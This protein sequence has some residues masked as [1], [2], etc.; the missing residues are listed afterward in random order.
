MEFLVGELTGKRPLLPPNVEMPKE[1]ANVINT[2]KV[3]SELPSDSLGAYVISMAKSASDVMAVVLL[4]VCPPL[5]PKH[6]HRP[7]HLHARIRSIHTTTVHAP[8]YLQHHAVLST[9]PLQAI[10]WAQRRAL[11]VLLQAATPPPPPTPPFPPE[12]PCSCSLLYIQGA[13]GLQKQAGLPIFSPRVCQV[14]LRESN[15]RVIPSTRA[16]LKIPGRP[17][18]GFAAFQ[19]RACALRGH[20]GAVIPCLH[21]FGYSSWPSTC[22]PTSHGA[23][24]A[25]QASQRWHLCIGPAA[26]ALLSPTVFSPLVLKNHLAWA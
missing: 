23:S 15:V 8:A 25:A 7:V 26:I 10:L 12:T 11:V 2:F 16:I 4:Q 14:A 20:A 17:W 13:T 18:Q 19:G 5:P 24:S 3:I 9:A 6:H 1:V 21:L 22:S